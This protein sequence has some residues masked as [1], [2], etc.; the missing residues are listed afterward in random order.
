MKK[1]LE[2]VKKIGIVLCLFFMLTGCNRPDASEGKQQQEHQD[3]ED[4]TNG[5]QNENNQS[6]VEEKRDFFWVSNLT[7]RTFGSDGVFY[8]KSGFLYFLD[9]QTSVDDIICDDATCNHKKGKCTA[10]FEALQTFAALEDD[11]LLVVTDYGSD[12]IGDMYLYETG[13][14]GGDRKEVA[15]L[16]NMQGIYQ[17]IFSDEYIIATYYNNYDDNM[18]PIE[19]NI[20]RIYVYD[21]EKKSGEIVW[22]NRRVNALVP[23][24]AYAD[25]KVYF[26]SF[27]IDATIEEVLEYGYKSSYV[28]ERAR[29]EFCSVDISDKTVRVIHEGLEDTGSISVCHDTIFFSDMGKLWMYNIATEEVSVL[30]EKQFRLSG[31]YGTDWQLLQDGNEYFT[32]TP[33]GVLTKAGI[34]ENVGVQAV[35]PEVMYAFDYNTSDG[36]GVL[37]HWGTKEFLEEGGESLTLGIGSEEK[38]TPPEP[39]F[40]IPDTTELVTWVVP[41]LISADEIWNQVNRLNRK[42][43]EDG[44]SIA[45]DVKTLPM[46]SYRQQLSS[47]LEEGEVDIASG[48]LDM[49]G[50]DAEYVQD[51]IRKDSFEE[52][53][54]YLASADGKPLMDWYSEAEW[55]SVETDGK[56][57]SIPNQQGMRG[58]SYLAFNKKYVTKEMLQKFDGTP[59]ELEQLLLSMDIPDKVY[60][61]LGNYS[62]NSLA[63]MSGLSAEGGVIFDLETGMAENPLQ[64]EKFCQYIRELNTLHT[65]GYIR[66][67]DITE[68]VRNGNFVVWITSDYDALYEEMKDS[69]L[70]VPLPFTLQNILS[71]TTS[72]N[73]HST[74]KEAALK[75]LTLLY[76]NET[77]ANMFMFG[78]E[79]VH[80]QLTDGYVCN[81]EG[82]ALASWG[83]VVYGIYDVAHPLLGDDMTVTRRETKNAVYE[84]EYCLDSAVLGF[85]P[86]YSGWETQ[87]A[88]VKNI[89]NKKISELWKASDL[90]SELKE[91]TDAF[92]AAGGNEL[93]EELNRQVKELM[94]KAKQ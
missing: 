43:F 31:S 68:E 17:V 73:R 10:H 28:D 22:E 16:A 60:P 55:K 41:D 45:L 42:L 14:N 51:L 33:N 49:Q 44:Y 30:T 52:L 25:G 46:L 90:E 19:E 71:S 15:Y 80:Y 11:H 1:R 89:W 75:L 61:V 59:A 9:A 12:K 88:E 39:K 27:Y 69:V 85:K 26:Y 2:T 87:K 94:Q 37:T 50:S 81:M 79:G 3:T 8:A 57:Y 77:Y 67:S 34:R 83:G 66:A 20:A 18:T 65:K 84:S 64:N 56:I 78:E 40:D 86:D 35:F 6:G 70:V 53:S 29:W 5:E 76:T 38:E 54:G 62:I 24:I 21:R 63:A 72:I 92:E 91:A 23:S 4:G 82:D 58:G 93:L 7:G 47:I 48:G 36:N 74:Q 32:C 13:V